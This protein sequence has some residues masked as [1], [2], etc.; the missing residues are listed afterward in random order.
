[1]DP[2]AG[3][4]YVVRNGKPVAVILGIEEYRQILEQL[5]DIEDLKALAELEH[6]PLELRSFE[7]YI[8]E[9]TNDA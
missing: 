9:R 3:P 4:E 1:M 6:Q 8:A 5:D 7:D 2:K